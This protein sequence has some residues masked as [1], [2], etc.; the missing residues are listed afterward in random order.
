MEGADM[1]EGFYKGNR[2][3]N[4]C[5]KCKNTDPRQIKESEEQPRCSRCGT[6]LRTKSTGLALSGGGYRAAL[7]HLGSLWRLNELG[8]LKRIA[9]ITS[10]S[11]GSITAAYLGLNWKNLNFGADGVATNF[12]DEIVLPLR[13]FFSHSIELESIL[14]GLARPYR[15]KLFHEATLKN[16]PSDEEGPRF[17]IYA[18]SLQTGASVRFSNPYL[19]EYHLGEMTTTEDIEIATAVAASSAIPLFM[20]PV[21]LKLDP[22]HWTDFRKGKKIKKYNLKASLPQ[23]RGL[24]S[25]MYLDDGGVYDNLGLERIWDRYITVLVSDAGYPFSIM[26]G[27]PLKLIFTFRIRR[28]IDLI[29]DQVR[30]LRMRWLIGDLREKKMQGAYW[31]TATH[32]DRYKSELKQKK[33]PPALARD[34]KTTGSLCRIRTRLNSFSAMEQEQLI[35]WGYALTDAAMRCYVLKKGARSGRLPYPKRLI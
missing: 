10:V 26:E 21:R 29:N 5:V 11:G 6:P 13:K 35:D 18:T 14:F 9:E 4:Y 2:Q 8:W 33:R 1:E 32:I 22:S 19:A 27:S 24:R 28:P 23:R 15:R 25:K 12:V 20:T 30:R 31:G 16:L 3:Q 34:N 17:T 7:F